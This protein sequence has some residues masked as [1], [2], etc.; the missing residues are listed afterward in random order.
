LIKQNHIFLKNHSSCREGNKLL[1]DIKDSDLETATYL[2]FNVM[3]QTFYGRKDAAT[4]FAAAINC[5]PQIMRDA[6]PNMLPILTPPGINPYTQV[7]LHD[8]FGPCLD[9]ADATI[10][11]PEPS[12]KI[13][14]LVKNEKSD[15]KTLKL[16]LIQAKKE[17]REKIVMVALGDEKWEDKK[18][19]K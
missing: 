18:R 13:R 12:E 6:I 5:R 14:A 4:S 9:A 10:T 16:K 1:L 19:V 2:R 11:C 3:K 8:K 7:E 15:R 17:A